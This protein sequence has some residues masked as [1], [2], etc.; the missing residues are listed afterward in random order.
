MKYGIVWGQLHDVEKAVEEDMR[1][2]NIKLET[3]DE[4]EKWVLMKE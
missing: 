1:P 2:E 4:K 3:L